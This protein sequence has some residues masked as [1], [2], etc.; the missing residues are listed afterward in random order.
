MKKIT[1]LLLKT[2]SSIELDIEKDYKKQRK[3]HEI[4][5]LDYLKFLQ[6]TV[7]AAVEVDGREIPIRL[8]YPKG[9]IQEGMILFFHGG[10]WVTGNVESYNKACR[11]LAI[12][13]NQIVI[14][15][16]YRL[17]PEF[18]FPNGLED[19]YDITKKFFTE[20]EIVNVPASKITLMGDSAGGNL[21]AAVSL[22]A[23]D[24]GEFNV[25]KQILLYPVTYN[26][27]SDTSPYSSII[28]EGKDYVLTTKSVLDYMKLYISK[29]EDF[30]NPYVAPLLAKD[31]S[32]QPKTLIITAEHDPLRDEGEAYGKKLLESQCEVE[33]HRVLD[34]IHGFFN[35]SVLLKSNKE[36]YIYIKK[37]I[38]GDDKIEQKS[39]E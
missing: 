3:V 34:T 25:S 5:H 39:K 14:S 35:F 17:A 8:F 1:K 38:S 21:A 7:D 13:T 33:I 19:C 31:L 9:E 32:D 30:Y 28:T 18:P 22:L 37:F 36:A 12:E 15:V 29:E 10:G 23:R 6:K 24:R 4:M 16:E 26:D 2:I 20:N 11:T 27:H